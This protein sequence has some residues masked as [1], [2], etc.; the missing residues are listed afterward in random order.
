MYLSFKLRIYKVKLY[1]NVSTK[2]RNLGGD[3]IMTFGKFKGVPLKCLPVDYIKWLI[4]TKIMDKY[5]LLKMN[6]DLWMQEDMFELHR[7]D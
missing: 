4:R 5:S 1:Q 2:S 7:D 3:Y 6:Y